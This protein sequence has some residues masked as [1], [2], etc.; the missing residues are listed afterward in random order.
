M[1]IERPYKKNSALLTEKQKTYMAEIAAPL[2]PPEPAEHTCAH[3]NRLTS[4]R[5]ANGRGG[6]NG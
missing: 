6:D 3:A 1:P 4:Q 5:T 2:E